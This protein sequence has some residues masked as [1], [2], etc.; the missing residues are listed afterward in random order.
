MSQ[1][2]RDELARVNEIFH[3]EG[4]YG[5]RGILL[6]VKDGGSFCS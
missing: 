4:S 1:K 5:R 2:Q 3:E 6:M